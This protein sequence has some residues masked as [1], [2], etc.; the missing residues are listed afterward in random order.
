MSKIIFLISIVASFSFS[1]NFKFSFFKKETNQEPTLLVI[2]GI[3]GNE[4]GGYF[5]PTVLNKHYEIKKGNLWIIPN[6]NFDSILKDS[7]GINGDMNRKFSNIKKSDKDF[8]VVEKI[9]KLILDKKVDLIL[10]LHDGQ[11]FYRDRDIDKE[12]NSKAWGQACIIDQKD[13]PN[14]KFGDLAQIAKRVSSEAS[15]DLEK[16]VHEFNVKNTQTKEKDES[17]RQSLTYF[18]IKNNKPAFA[19]ETSKNIVDLD[20][21]VYYQLKSI[22]EFMDIMGIEFKRDFELTRENVKTILNDIGVLE[23]PTQHISLVLNN[24]KP[25]ISNFPMNNKKLEYSSKNPL[26]AVLKEKNEVKVMN[27]NILV[28]KL[29]PSYYDFDNSLENVEMTIDGQKTTKKLG[30]IVEV[31]KDFMIKSKKGYR[32]NIIGFSKDKLENESDISVSLND[33]VKRFS[34]DK[35]EKIFRIEFYKDKK[36]CGMILVRFK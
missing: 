8:E 36:F 28:T 16:D 26:I 24:I 22:E 35:S 32:V 31:N 2:G 30:D 14:V 25:F 29:N 19:I 27:G 13:I 20:L 1:Q 34:L 23:I 7:R 33:F 4:P 15:V 6:L 17:M 10:N 11:G 3:H 5:A 9:K 18:A 21:K 12:F